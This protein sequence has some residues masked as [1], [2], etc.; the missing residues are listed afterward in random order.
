MSDA[1]EALRVV[2]EMEIAAPPERVFR[3]LTDPDE[4]PLWW[5]DEES[6]ETTGAEIDLRP[7]GEYRLEGTSVRLGTFE[8]TGSY[9]TVDPPRRLAYTWTPSWD[10]GARD[11]VVEI[12]LEPT[13]TGTRVRVVH[14]AFATEKARDEHA[15]GWPTVLGFLKKY[16]E[17]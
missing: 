3:A 2:Q 10:E 4:I 15:G 8:V 14:T 1:V 16:L 12:A 17:W 9:R 11:S 5:G 13:E 6:Y 7:G